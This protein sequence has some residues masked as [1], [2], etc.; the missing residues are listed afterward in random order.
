[1]I[2]VVSGP[3]RSGTSMMMRALY[4]GGIPAIYQPDLEELNPRGDY[5]ANP[6]G[7]YE[8][9]QGYY[10]NAKFLR[11]IP[12]DSVIKIMFDGLASLPFRD[13]KII[14]MERDPEEIQAS[15]ERMD[16]HLSQHD[17][18]PTADWPAPF[19]CFRPYKQE[20]INHVLDICEARLDMHLIRV[21]F[22]K[23]L[24]HPKYELGSL[25]L[26]GVPIN[27]DKAAAVVN[28]KLYRTRQGNQNVKHS[29][30]RSI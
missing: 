20:D 17:I 9:G 19:N 30:G 21:N 23:V 5:T 16:S 27:V 10:L 8:V 11:E 28:P 24:R 13:Y 15:L 4:E 2:Y 25:N 3:R 7:L 22:R 14:F 29:Q 26:L 18:K 1:M 6:G 12:D